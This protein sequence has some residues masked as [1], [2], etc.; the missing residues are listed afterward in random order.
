MMQLLLQ[1]R[2]KISKNLNNKLRYHCKSNSLIFDLK[3]LLKIDESDFR[4]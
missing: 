4:L 2:I 3:H 1:W